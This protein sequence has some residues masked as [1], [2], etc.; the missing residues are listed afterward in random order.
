MNSNPSKEEET[1]A[2]TKERLLRTME[3]ADPWEAVRERPI[4]SAAFAAVLGAAVGAISGFGG[5]TV[6]KAKRAGIAI[7]IIFGL[8]KKIYD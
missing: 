5:N 2:E 6:T 8:L 7:D 1:L 3:R 4:R